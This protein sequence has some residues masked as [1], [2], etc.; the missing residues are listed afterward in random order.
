MGGGL[1]RA[2]AYAKG[3]VIGGGDTCL[4]CGWKLAAAMRRKCPGANLGCPMDAKVLALMEAA[5]GVIDAAGDDD[6]VGWQ[7]AAD[8]LEMA[9]RPL[10]AAHNV[11]VRDAP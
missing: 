6:P 4:T 9:L 11:E 10:R 7:E 5:E 8:K 1:Q 3:H 2:Y